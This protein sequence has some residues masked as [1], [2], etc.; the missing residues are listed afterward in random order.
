MTQAMCERSVDSAKTWGKQGQVWGADP[1]SLKK[2]NKFKV[3]EYYYYRISNIETK[4]KK[5]SDIK[6]QKKKCGREMHK[7]AICQYVGEWQM[8]NME[9]G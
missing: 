6:R 9:D 2:I 5:K 4:E 3:Y 1:C 7:Q 8:K